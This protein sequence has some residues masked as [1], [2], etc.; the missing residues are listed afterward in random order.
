MTTLEYKSV[1]LEDDET[2][3][4][5]LERE[6]F[7]VIRAVAGEKEVEKARALVWDWLESL[8]TGIK[9]GEPDTWADEAWPGH[10]RGVT[11]AAQGAAHLGAT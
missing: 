4:S 8:G 6:G 9:K 10:G 11:V 5:E 3:K 2:W 1:S 7:T